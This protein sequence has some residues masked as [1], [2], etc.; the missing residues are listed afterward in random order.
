METFALKMVDF[1]AKGYAR[2]ASS[3]ALPM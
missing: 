3:A 2:F 1:S